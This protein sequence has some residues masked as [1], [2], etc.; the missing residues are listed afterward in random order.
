MRKRNIFVTIRELDHKQTAKETRI[1]ALIPRWESKSIFL[2]GNNDDLLQEMR[3]FPRGQHDDVLDSLAY[4]EQI[5]YKP[6]DSRDLNDIL[7][8]EEPLYPLIGI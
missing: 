7:G 8:P 6:Y 5:A 4:G 2:I 1:R 3:V